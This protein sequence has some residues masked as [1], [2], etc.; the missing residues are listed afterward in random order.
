[1]KKFTLAMAIIFAIMLSF[2]VNAQSISIGVGG[3]LT[4]VA[5]SED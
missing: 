1:M 3:G 5:G 2:T 4:N